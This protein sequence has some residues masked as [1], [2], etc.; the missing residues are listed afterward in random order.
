[1][2]VQNTNSLIFLTGMHGIPW[3]P[4]IPFGHDLGSLIF[5]L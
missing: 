4:V 5:D 3:K 1:M 2:E